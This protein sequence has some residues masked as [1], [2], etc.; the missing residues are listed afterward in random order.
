M[1]KQSVLNVDVTITGSDGYS[2]G[3]GMTQ[4]RTLAVSGS[5]IALVGGPSANTL[6]ISGSDITFI[7]TPFGSTLELSGSGTM[8]MVA[9][10]SSTLTFPTSSANIAG[11]NVTQSFTAPQFFNQFTASV[12]IHVEAGLGAG[13]GMDVAGIAKFSGAISAS[14][15]ISIDTSPITINSGLTIRNAP[16]YIS[17]SLY[18]SS[19]VNISGSLF[20]TGI[21]RISG[22][23]FITGSGAVTGTLIV[24]N[25]FTSIGTSVMSGSLTVSGSEVIS[26]SLKVLGNTEVTGTFDVKN[27]FAWIHTT[28]S[29]LQQNVK[30]G[31]WTT[32]GTSTWDIYTR[33]TGGTSESLLK[34]SRWGHVIYFTR[35]SPIGEITASALT[36]NNDAGGT[37]QLYNSQSTVTTL[38][39]G[40]GT[41]SFNGGSVTIGKAVSTEAN[42]ILDVSGA[43]TVTGSMVVSSSLTVT[44]S[45]YITGSATAYF[46]TPS[47]FFNPVSFSSSVR[48]AGSYIIT[49]SISGGTN[50]G[51]GLGATLDLAY[52]GTEK[53]ARIAWA[54]SGSI[55]F[56]A[57][58]LS[59]GG[60]KDNLIQF[61]P[62]TTADVGIIEVWNG[63]GLYI[64]TGNNTNPI[65]FKINRTQVGKMHSAGMEVTGTMLSSGNTTVGGNLNLTGHLL[66]TSTDATDIGGSTSLVRSI[67]ASELNTVLFAQNTITLL[68]GWFYVTKDQ[69]TLP[70]DMSAAASMYDFGKTMTP[71]DFIVLRN[72]GQ[73]EYIQVGAQYQDTTYYITRDLDGS[74]ANAWVKGAPYAVLGYTNDGRIEMLAKVGAYGPRISISKQGATYNASTEVVRL[75]DLNGVGGYTTENFGFFAGD[76]S[77]YV[78]I[79]GGNVNVSGQ[80]TA[81]AGN[82]GGWTTDTSKFYGNYGLAYVGVQKPAASTTKV[83]FASASDSGGTSARFYVT[84]EGQIVTSDVSGTIMFDSNNQYIDAKNSYVE[85]YRDYTSSISYAVGGGGTGTSGELIGGWFYAN[86][87]ATKAWFVF[88]AWMRNTSANDEVT[89]RVQFGIG[90]ETYQNPYSASIEDPIV[91]DSSTTIGSY[92]TSSTMGTGRKACFTGDTQIIMRNGMTKK[93]S[94]V[95]ADEYVMSYDSASSVFTASRVESVFTGSDQY[96]RVINGAI[97]ATAHHPFLTTNGWT[98]VKDLKVGDVLRTKDGE[99]KIQYIE[100]VDRGYPVSVYTLTMG[101]ESHPTF[102]ANGY[103]VHNKPASS[104]PGFLA[105]GVISVP[106]PTPNAWYRWA[107][108]MEVQSN[109]GGATATVKMKRMAVD[110]GR[111]LGASQNFVTY[112][113]T[114][115]I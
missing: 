115:V 57:D 114:N 29:G 21:A 94:E 45:F 76:A 96:Y 8:T 43:V 61:N 4:K 5:D 88:N 69:G 20:E 78:K 12:G 36:M 48:Q 102:I 26:G 14:G 106:I 39:N 56:M 40:Y 105:P 74:G 58:N 25:S 86:A 23:L 16:L 54:N 17:S 111:T 112:D 37:L 70:Q 91:A 89:G 24:S 66:P 113:E 44:G 99:N 82:I 18:A 33:D 93:I 90:Q 41:S 15:G 79:A 31:E 83:F 38:L 2:I 59:S 87:T 95:Q 60:S 55:S 22:S 3:G 27:N 53:Y 6:T 35:Q 1:A 109:P 107:A 108:K 49:G 98:E 50:A 77:N 11:T 30:L 73:V 28:G 34:A 75:G 46:D 47:Y 72:S 7:G 100:D 65:T 51:S 9:S 32:G 19:S 84:S 104:Q 97:S 110:I 64:G 103:I 68:G 92:Q 85:V 42:G 52:N 10:G 101:S 67:W 80:I 13:V 71:N 62:Q 63:G 81:S